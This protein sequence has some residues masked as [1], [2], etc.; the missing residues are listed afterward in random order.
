MD[1]MLTFDEQVEWNRL[2]DLHLYIVNNLDIDNMH[3]N[4]ISTL[5]KGFAEMMT[6]TN[7]KSVLSSIDTLLSETKKQ[8]EREIQDYE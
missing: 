1:I 8:Y 2:Q 5:V 7:K 3:K 6:E 4:F